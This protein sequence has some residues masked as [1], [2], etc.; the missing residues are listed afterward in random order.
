[1]VYERDLRRERVTHPSHYT[2]RPSGIECIEVTEHMSFCLGNAVMC[3]WL[4]GLEGDN[5]EGYLTKAI[6][7]L[8]RE[9]SR[10]SEVSDDA[11]DEDDDTLA[12]LRDFFDDDDDKEDTD[13]DED[14]AP[15][16]WDNLRDKDDDEADDCFACDGYCD[17]SCL[18]SE[19]EDTDEDESDYF[20]G[21]YSCDCD[22][23]CFDSDDTDDDEDESTTNHRDD[24]YSDGRRRVTVAEL[25]ERLAG[26]A[27][28]DD[29]LELLVTSILY[30]VLTDN[31]T[32]AFADDD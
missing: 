4:A 27:T 26:D 19:D 17:G 7:Y 16:D 1:M 18:D 3:I 11:S 29:P 12:T 22:G 30:H 21:E 6:W 8:V 24:T 13:G 28:G 20:C 31:L 2:T 14:C 15:V 5:A 9:I 10:I 32:D 23:S 25:R